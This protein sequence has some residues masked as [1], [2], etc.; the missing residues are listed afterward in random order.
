MDELLASA[1]WMNVKC[2]QWAMA[3]PKRFLEKEAP[4]EKAD[5]GTTHSKCRRGVGGGIQGLLCA[6]Q[7]SSIR[8]SDWNY[9]LLWWVREYTPVHMYV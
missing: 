5:D 6:G 1:A 9:F 3:S 8:S 2:T 4:E 7:E